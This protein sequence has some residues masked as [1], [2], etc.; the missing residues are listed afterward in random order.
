MKGYDQ[1]LHINKTLIR[2][3]KG[4]R[5]WIIAIAAL[6]VMVLVGMTMFANSIGS[7]LG[8][9]YDGTYLHCKSES[10]HKK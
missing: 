8:Q 9:L 2:M 5:G 10:E 7:I 6:K 1:V 4:F 3:S